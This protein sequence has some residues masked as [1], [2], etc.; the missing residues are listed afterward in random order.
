M[1]SETWARAQPVAGGA[2][3]VSE[4]R[5]SR[6][7]SPRV[8]AAVLV[9]LLISY[10]I[11]WLSFDS[12]HRTNN[13]FMATYVASWLVR[14][15]HHTQLYD[16][17]TQL[18]GYHLFVRPGLAAPSVEAPFVG[19]PIAALLAV[20]L[21]FLSA[22]TAY[23]AWSALQVCLLIVAVAIAWRSAPH[24]GRKVGVE[25]LAMVLIPLASF[26]TLDLL[27]S[28]Q[29]DGLSAL[30]I[31]LAYR[32]WRRDRYAS[33]SACLVATAI[34]AKPQLALGLLA[35]LG[36]WRDRRV[37]AG[38]LAAGVVLGLA[39]LAVVGGAGAT[40]WWHL[41]GA[42]AHLYSATG[43]YGFIALPSA[44]FG[45]GPLVTPVT[46]A[47]I[48]VLL[49]LCLVV[50]DRLRTVRL[51][52]GPA[53][54]AAACLS[55]LAAPHSYA[56]DAVMLVPALVWVFA[57]YSPFSADRVIRNRARIM[58][59]LWYASTITAFGGPPLPDV[60]LRAGNAAVW[61]L[62]GIA[63]CLWKTAHVTDRSL[64]VHPARHTARSRTVLG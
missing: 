8:V 46:Y 4:P 20:P 59:A 55:L 31:A 2:V 10:L 13:D 26:A 18:R 5:V 21:T 44:W 23:G 9:A 60:V 40:A 7:V 34:L 61:I 38:A 6:H 48:I 33:G 63:V 50:G 27:R 12:S 62:I 25:T 16:Y 11:V 1:A 41:V 24:G 36:G 53:F 29:W 47:G 52:L 56:Y 17:A 22:A 39:S 28:G 32:C 3:A 35:F 14:T 37:L 64:H 49:G 30:G 58:I 43:L 51:S 45:S 57:E 15:G 19:V 42:D 54:A